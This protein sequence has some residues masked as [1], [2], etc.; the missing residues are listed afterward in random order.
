MARKRKRGSSAADLSNMARSKWPPT[1]P[2]TS[3][4]A[5]VSREPTRKPERANLSK[6]NPGQATHVVPRQR[7]K[8]TADADVHER[9]TERCRCR[10]DKAAHQRKGCW[11]G[12]PE[13]TEQGNSV[14]AI[15]TGF[16]SNRRRH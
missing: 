3:I 16:E 10:H 12:C 4:V 7:G 6:Q 11:C 13:Y 2:D 1:P 15:S 5:G 8:E 9:D 14:R